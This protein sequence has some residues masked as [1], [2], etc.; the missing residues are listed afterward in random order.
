MYDNNNKVDFHAIVPMATPDEQYW[1]EEEQRIYRKL[2]E[3]RRLREEALR[4]KV[5]SCVR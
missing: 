2:Q 3:E 5:C 4:A 1:V